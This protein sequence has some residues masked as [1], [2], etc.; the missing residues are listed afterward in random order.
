M[1]IK[2]PSKFVSFCGLPIVKFSVIKNVSSEN[3]S[4]IIGDGVVV[5]VVLF[6]VVVVNKVVNIVASVVVS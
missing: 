3:P 1:P 5:V 2:A 6:V 4:N